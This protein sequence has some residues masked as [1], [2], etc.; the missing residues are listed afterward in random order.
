MR[1]AASV[2]YS[3]LSGRSLG[4]PSALTPGLVEHL[5]KVWHRPRRPLAGVVSA[6]A[7][8]AAS[9]EGMGLSGA[10]REEGEHGG[11][12]GGA[13]WGKTGGGGSQAPMLTEGVVAVA[14]VSVSVRSSL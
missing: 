12:R 8:S 4:K 13:P 10:S 11:R 5:A 2:L 14:L 9:G 3:V 1:I 7:S 6:T